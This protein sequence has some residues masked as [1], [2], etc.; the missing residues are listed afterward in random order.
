MGPDDTTSGYAKYP[1]ED[2]SLLVVKCQNILSVRLSQS[3][4]QNLV[5]PWRGCLFISLCI[6][7]GNQVLP[8]E[9]EY[10]ESSI[11]KRKRKKKKKT[12][13]QPENS[14]PGVGAPSP[15][16]N[17]GK[18]P[19]AMQRK[20]QKANVAEVGSEATSSTG[21]ES[22]SEHPPVVPIHN[23]RKRPRKKSLR[24]RGEIPELAALPPEDMS[25]SSPSNGQPQGPV[26]RGSLTG[27]A[28][29]LKKKRKL[30]V[31]S[32]SGNGLSTLAWPLVQ[33]EASLARPMEGGSSQVTLF[34]CRRLQKK[35]AEPSSLDLCDLS[36][37]KTAILK[38]R[39]KMREMSTLVEHN[40]VL[41]SEVRQTQALGSSGTFGPLK[42]QQLRTENDFVKFDTL[43]SPKPLFFRKAKSNPSTYSPGPAVQL[44]KTP[45]S[46]KKVTF[47]LNR[48]MTAEFKKTDKS[49]L[50]SPTGPSRVAFNPEQRPLHGVL[51]TPTSSPASTPLAIKKPLTITPKRRPTAMDFF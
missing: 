22:G 16:Q 2:R 26:I 49:I 31:A 8:I 30:R 47:G 3:H 38:K 35:K 50:V 21:E 23:K 20:A 15:E 12:H 48:N 43:F 5:S 37:Q 6:F 34:Q 28:Q 9:E 41:E 29:V 46:S 32:I 17:K 39:K 13:P 25:Q 19:E 44:S 1:K 24:T 40:G 27:G 45:S 11:Q 33:K 4:Q 18:E 36:N 51:K 42:K 7:T 14:G 10:T